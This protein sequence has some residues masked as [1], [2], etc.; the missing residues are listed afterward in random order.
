[1]LGLNYATYAHLNS[2]KAKTR[3][4]VSSQERKKP[5][6]WREEQW[7]QCYTPGLVWGHILIHKWENV[8]LIGV[9]T[10]QGWASK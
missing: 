9:A 3:V 10:P 6:A 8:G 2:H 5:K 1:M 7:S 4:M